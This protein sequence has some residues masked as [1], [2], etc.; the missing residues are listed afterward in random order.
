MSRKEEMDYV[1]NPFSINLITSLSKSINDLD[2]RQGFILGENN[3]HL[4]NPEEKYISYVSKVHSNLIEVNNQ[5]SYIRIFLMRYPF[6]Q[7]YKKNNIS[8]LE[9]IQYHMEVLFHKTHTVLEI[10]KLLVN[11]VYDL[12]IPE[13]DCNWLNMCKYI[14]RKELCM[15]YI[16]SYYKTFENII[17]SRHLSSHR[18]LFFDN[19]KDNIEIDMGFSLYKF[20]G[21]EVDEELKMIFPLRFIEF[22]IKRYKKSRVELV[23]KII[24]HKNKILKEFLSSLQLEF[25]RQKSNK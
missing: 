15:K 19:Q 14:N 12:K 11:K 5:I 9:Y 17:D 24:L 22:E 1:N 8:E 13:K 16:D 7:H 4:L 20:E 3:H 10:M 25:Q 21:Y 23:E 6:K 18:G 2:K